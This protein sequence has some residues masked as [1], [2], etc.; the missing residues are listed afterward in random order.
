[1]AVLLCRSDGKPAVPTL[2]QKRHP[3]ILIKSHAL[4]SAASQRGTR[5]VN[6]S[7]NQ[8]ASEEQTREKV[9]RDAYERYGNIPAGVAA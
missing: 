5:V 1:M 8:Y 2:D 4:V 9:W 3:K 7:E 6:R